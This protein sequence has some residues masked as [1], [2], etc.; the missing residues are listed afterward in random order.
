MG[1]REVAEEHSQQHSNATSHPS[2]HR[3]FSPSSSHVVDR[4]VKLK[5]SDPEM[6]SE[7]WNRL[8]DSTRE[9]ILE[10][11]K[12]YPNLLEKEYPLLLL[13]RSG[14]L[15]GY[16]VEEFEEQVSTTPETE[17]VETVV[18][19]HRKEP[20]RRARPKSARAKAPPRPRLE[21]VNVEL[22]KS[23]PRAVRN[24]RTTGRGGS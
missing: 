20:S 6:F 21:S 16:E 5:N 4:L 23:L 2:F 17:A 13:H 19:L 15:S 10:Y 3:T 18:A 1:H 14:S 12:R 7:A 9:N 11:L 24:S 8:P 22:V